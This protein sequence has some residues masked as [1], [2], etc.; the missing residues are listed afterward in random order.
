MHPCARPSHSCLI[1][2]FLTFLVNKVHLAT[3]LT[4]TSMDGA[5]M[6]SLC[7]QKVLLSGLAQDCIITTAPSANELTQKLAS[8]HVPWETANGI[9]L[10][11]INNNTTTR[12]NILMLGKIQ[13]PPEGALSFQ[14]EEPS[15]QAPKTVPTKQRTR[16][17][18]TSKT[19]PVAKDSAT[20]KMKITTTEP[21][22]A[23]EV[24]LDSIYTL[25]REAGVLTTDLPS[26]PTKRGPKTEEEKRK[27]NAIYSRRK[28]VRKK[29]EFQVLEKES[30][31]LQIQNE[32]LAKEQEQLEK[33]L[34]QAQQMAADID[35]GRMSTTPAATAPFHSPRFLNG[36]TPAL[37][38]S[39]DASALGL[40]RP[41]FGSTTGFGF[42]QSQQQQSSQMFPSSLHQHAALLQQM[43]G[44]GIPMPPNS[45]V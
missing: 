14:S 3:T 4:D 24:S 1:A 17:L 9:A 40:A 31:R 45:T 7:L 8:Y 11:N 44:K 5:T 13:Q 16:R 18:P 19:G 39:K 6:S 35:S 37:S 28:Y 12:A 25:R 36:T 15:P 20:K 30:A 34:A 27:R 41:A 22:T 26:I 23:A 38:N 21:Q 32:A 42:G 2:L 33:S 10:P 29:I 43:G